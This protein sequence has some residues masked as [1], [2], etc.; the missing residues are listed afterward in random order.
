MLLVGFNTHPRTINAT[1]CGRGNL[2]KVLVF[3]LRKL[4]LVERSHIFIWLKESFVNNT[5]I[6]S[7]KQTCQFM[8]RSS[9]ISRT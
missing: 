7:F 6:L 8:A 2:V 5:Q 1:G 3:Q 9:I 4:V